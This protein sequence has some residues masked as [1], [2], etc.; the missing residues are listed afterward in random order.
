MRTELATL[1]F[2]LRSK[3]TL[4]YPNGALDTFEL[5][6]QEL[7]LIAA[8]E[9][10]RRL[11]KLKYKEAVARA[12]SRDGQRPPS[13][14]SP[15]ESPVP[16]PEHH[17]HHHHHHHR[18]LPSSSKLKTPRRPHT[19]AGP[20]DAGRGSLRRKEREVLRARSS[21]GTPPS[22]AER[23]SPADNM[24]L[25]APAGQTVFDD[26]GAFP[27]S[28]SPMSTPLGTPETPD[29]FVQAWEEELERIMKQSQ[30]QSEEMVG[31]GERR[32]R[33]MLD[34]SSPAAT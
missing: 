22:S 26:N 33:V 28:P 27:P 7:C 5:E 34:V 17:H 8:N 14:P 18:S 6:D 13:P 12:R 31:F 21:R 9:S 1:R 10:E 30:R 25:S 32:T 11:A 3:V 16:P 19:S 29:S 23:A 2:F 24:L 20:R 4:A 15:C